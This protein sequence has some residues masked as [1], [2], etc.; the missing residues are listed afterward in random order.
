[1]QRNRHIEIW[2]ALQPRNMRASFSGADIFIVAIQIDSV[3]VFARSFQESAWIEH[4]TDQPICAGV[5][6]A[7]F[8]HFN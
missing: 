4:G 6:Y 5:E 2:L 1:M 3:G 7:A 8:D